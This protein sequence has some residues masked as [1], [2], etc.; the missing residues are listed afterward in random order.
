MICFVR[1]FK[2]NSTFSELL[3][4]YSIAK[5]CVVDLLHLIFFFFFFATFFGMIYHLEFDQILNF[6]K[7]APPNNLPKELDLENF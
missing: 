4:F 7:E 5:F 2:L 1:F 6:L 3:L